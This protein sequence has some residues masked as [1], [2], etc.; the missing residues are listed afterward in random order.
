[1][2]IESESRSSRSAGGVVDARICV[3]LSLERPSWRCE[4]PVSAGVPFPRGVLETT[5]DLVVTAGDDVALTTQVEPLA[6]WPDGTVRWALV[7]FVVPSARGDPPELS[8]RHEP[9]VHRAEGPA[10]DVSAIDS[11]IEVATGVFTFVVRG[12]GGALLE[13]ERSGDPASRSAC[14]AF[15]VDGEGRRR[16]AIVRSARIATRGPVRTTIESAGELTSDRGERLCEFSA[17]VHVYAARG[18]VKMDFAVR[19]PRAARHTGGLWDLGDPAS[20]LFR[21]LSLQWRFSEQPIAGSRWWLRTESGEE[22]AGSGPV[23]IAQG[24]SGGASSRSVNHVDRR[25]EVSLPFDGYRVR[26]ATPG[27]PQDLKGARC[28]PVVAIESASYRVSSALRQFWQNFPS[29]L[30]SS[31]E[32]LEVRLFPTWGEELHELQ[33][34]EQKRHTVYFLFEEVAK[35]S[36]DAGLDSAQVDAPAAGAGSAEERSTGG[37]ESTAGKGSEGNPLAWVERPALVMLPPGTIEE[38]GVFENFT[39]AEREPPDDLSRLLDGA[40]EG[41]SSFFAKRESADEYGWRHFGDVFADHERAYYKGAGPLVSHYNNQYDLLY[42]FLRQGARTGDARWLE[43]A[44]DL[45][46]HVIDIDIYHTEEDRP[47]YCHGLFWHTDHYLSAGRATHR[48]YSRDNAPSGDPSAYG[49]GPSNEHCYTAGL[50]YFYYL[51]GDPLARQAVCDLAGWIVRMDDGA[52]TILGQLDDGPTGLASQTASPDYHGPGRGAGNAVGAVLDGFRLTGERRY[53]EKAEELI[54][55]CIHPDDRMDDMDFDNI[56]LRWSYLVFLQSLGRYL[57]LKLEVNEQ[58]ETFAYARACLDH[59]ARWMLD[60]EQPYSEVLDRVEY[61]TETWPAH[62]F[63]KSAV[64]DLATRYGDPAMADAY[65]QKAEEY[66]EAA[67]AG[68]LSFETSGTTR[69]LAICLGLSGVRAYFAGRP[70]DSGE[71]AG[72]PRRFGAPAEFVPQKERVKRMARTPGGLLR[73]AFFLLKPAN[74]RK[75]LARRIW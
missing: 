61:P 47:Q 41:D 8:L 9:G 63:R 73:I 1:M 46:R 14:G 20:L 25:G 35:D 62:D 64:F 53:L 48:C 44:A 7:D 30:A 33:G 19:N 71:L 57:D 22:I 70:A 66:F 37:V 39:S 15:L 60:R 12:S 3:P 34:G 5:A 45:A 40:V 56:E 26:S 65:R 21:D 31:R 67:L 55:R 29:A 49:G 68:L 32:S 36:R 38:T 24:S 74:L 51:T 2:S 43:L 75:V 4:E 58:D 28:Q 16:V 10:L 59:Y 18:L 52:S 54:R 42:G 27:R 13:V 69:P 72:I 50:L 17:W 23:E 6:Y 11:R